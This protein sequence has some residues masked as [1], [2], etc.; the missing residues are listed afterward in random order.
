MV[1]TSELTSPAPPEDLKEAEV[2]TEVS[3]EEA[4]VVAEEATVVAEEATVVAEVATV[5]AEADPAVA[6][7]IVVA[8]EETFKI[9]KSM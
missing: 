4:T 5:V 9:D 7:V 8:P 1:E 6:E 3:L 2:D